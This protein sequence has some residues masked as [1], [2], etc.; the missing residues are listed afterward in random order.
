[1]SNNGKWALTHPAL[2]LVASPYLNMPFP[3]S[4][5]LHKSNR[6]QEHLSPMISNS[7]ENL[8][9]KLNKLKT[10]KLNQQLSSPAEKQI[11]L[12]FPLLS[13]THTLPAV[14]AAGAI[15]CQSEYRDCSWWRSTVMSAP[16]QELNPI[17]ASVV[18]YENK[19]P[20]YYS[21]R[22]HSF[23]PEYFLQPLKQR[24]LW[25]LTLQNAHKESADI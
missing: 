25:L 3:H 19:Q 15:L 8:S 5:T 9:S 4:F 23:H 11:C 7:A 22:T 13:L 10:V 14:A 16:Q 20:L 17:R 1:M 24:G 21:I 18:A 6:V 2:C 12:P